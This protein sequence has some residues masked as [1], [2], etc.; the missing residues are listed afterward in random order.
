MDA[1]RALLQEKKKVAAS[2]FGGRKYV[3][4]SDIEGARLKR[5]RKEEAKETSQKDAAKQARL[6]AERRA[7]ERHDSGADREEDLPREEVIRRLRLLGQPITLFGEEDAARA[8][9]LRRVQEDYQAQDEHAGGQQGNMMLALQRGELGRK[10]VGSAGASA[11]AACEKDKVEHR[12]DADAETGANVAE[13]GEP[14]DETTAAFM[15]AA[16]ALKEKREEEAMCVEDR[17]YKYLMRWFAEWGRDLD[18][19]PDD[20]KA[21]QSGH[22]MDLVYAQTE[23]Y[24][25]PLWKDLRRRDMPPKLVAGLYMI[26][27]AVQQRNYLQAYDIYVRL[28]IGKSPWPIGVTSVGIH[29]RSARDRSRTL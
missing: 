11:A 29:E 28:A 1:L 10:K 27:Q 22:Q 12:G 16:E 17:I 6:E 7:L 24:M 20:V 23:Q 15:R 21:S 8:A 3:K 14:E 2:D 26:F 4:Q 13:D 18:T 9:R 19:R 5:L 25:K